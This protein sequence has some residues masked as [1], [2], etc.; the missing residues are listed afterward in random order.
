MDRGAWG[1]TM[2]GVT[3]EPDMTEQ[4]NNNKTEAPGNVSN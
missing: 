4:L 3:K 1:A 2:H